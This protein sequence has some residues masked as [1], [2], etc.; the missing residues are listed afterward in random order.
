MPPKPPAK[1]TTAKKQ[2]VA[3]KSAAKKQPVAKKSV[4][5]KP[6]AK[7]GRIKGKITSYDPKT[8]RGAIASKTGDAKV[9]LDVAR[10]KILNKGYIPLDIGRD[11]EFAFE[12]NNA[13][14]IMIQKSA[15]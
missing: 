12:D 11:V 9:Q 2:P 15:D 4:A 1:K 8:G 10:T 14:E 13:T 6:V 7:T 3:K 5:K